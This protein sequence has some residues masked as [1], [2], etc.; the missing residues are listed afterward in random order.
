MQRRR[1]VGA[2]HGADIDH[3]R[4]GAAERHEGAEI[5]ETADAHAEEF[6]VFV[7]RQRGVDDIVARVVVADMGLVARLGPFHRPA[8]LAR[9]P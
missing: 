9:R 6:A 1:G 8:D 2:D 3:R 4:H 7:E 5:A